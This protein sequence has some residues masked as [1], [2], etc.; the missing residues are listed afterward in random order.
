MSVSKL[1]P[2]SKGFIQ[3][4]QK[5]ISDTK[6]AL[7]DSTLRLLSQLLIQWK[8]TMSASSQQKVRWMLLVHEL[9][10]L[11]VIITREM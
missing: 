10:S 1:F 9:L 4:I 2:F 6:P 8:S 3:F 7:L 5:D 11:F